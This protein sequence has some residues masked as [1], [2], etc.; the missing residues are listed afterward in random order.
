MTREEMRR[1]GVELGKRLGQP[2]DARSEVVPGLADFTA[3]VVYGGIWDRPQLPVADRLICTLAALGLLQRFAQLERMVATALDH[4]LP[5]RS[6]LEVFMQAGLY[7]GFD[8][9]ESAAACAHEVF[10]A[11][12]CTVPEE[13]PRTD[14]NEV[15]DARGRE[16]MATLHG[17]RG[18]EGY[19]A[20]GNAITG[21]LYPA[22]IRYGYGELWFRPGLNHRQRM[23]C[24][25][26]SFTVLGLERQLSEVR[27][28]RPERRPHAGGDHRGGDSDGPLRRISQGPERPGDRQRGAVSGGPGP[29]S[30][31]IPRIDT[32]GSSRDHPLA[33]PTPPFGNRTGGVAVTSKALALRQLGSTAVKT[34]ALGLGG[35]PIGGFR[36]HAERAS[37]APRPSAP[38]TTAGLALLRYVPLLRLRPQRAALRP[39]AEEP[40][41]RQLRALHQGRPLDGAARARARR[42]P[43]WRSGGLP[44]KATFDYSRDGTLRSLEQSLLR[45]GMS[46][47]DVVLIHDVDVV[48]H[49][50]RPRPTAASRRRWPAAIRRSWSCA[51][52]ASSAPSAPASTRRR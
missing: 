24:A 27:G 34:S 13:P 47:I 1:R 15:L 3:E 4:D 42:S 2:V 12:G 52:P 37:R 7:G 10:K 38:A 5:P 8:T 36:Y 49:G 43:G 19:A 25:L 46:R 44:F 41:A 48:S 17:E 6:I 26:A 14:S 50:S 51:A 32:R 29:T 39:R 35:A 31:R 30:A 16:L 18:Q 20:P 11:R 9:T 22:A 40:A 45:L 28:F 21:E 23:L 33:G